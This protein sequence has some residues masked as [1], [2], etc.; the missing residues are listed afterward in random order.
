MR[1]ALV[2]KIFALLLVVT[3]L[4]GATEGKGCVR[5]LASAPSAPVCGSS[6]APCPDTGAAADSPC[7][8]DEGGAAGHSDHCPSCP[9]HAPLAGRPVRPG[10]APLIVTFSSRDSRLALPEVYLPIF[11]PPQNCA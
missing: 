9:C 5:E 11:V 2:S 10:Y 6:G 8:P 1:F 7:C 4:M 3:L